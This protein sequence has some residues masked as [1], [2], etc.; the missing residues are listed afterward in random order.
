M[1]VALRAASVFLYTIRKDGD[2]IGF[3][4]LRQDADPDGPAVFVWVCW[5]EPGALRDCHAQVIA[6]LDEVAAR[7]GAK[8]LR[9]E[10]L[11][12]GWRG[13]SDYF[14]AVQTVFEREV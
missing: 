3:L 10:S 12:N 6:A 4:V 1:W 14:D 5:A 2:D 13:F 8:R 11:R 7:I 9:F